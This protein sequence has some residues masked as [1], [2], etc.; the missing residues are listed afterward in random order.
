MNEEIAV[1]LLQPSS[2]VV[3]ATIAVLTLLATSAV[4]RAEDLGHIYVLNARANSVEVFSS[5]RGG[6]ISP[7]RVISGSRTQISD[8][9]ELAVDP[10]GTV[11][12]LTRRPASIVEFSPGAS[13]N[14][15]PQTVLTGPH[16]GLLE[17][18]GLALGYGDA[19]FLAD[20]MS[21]V[22]IFRSGASG[23]AS[24][25]TTYGRQYGIGADISG[26]GV[27]LL[28]Q[29]FYA[30]SESNSV[31]TIQGVA[32]GYGMLSYKLAGPQSHLNGPKS[33]SVDGYGRIYVSNRDN[34]VLFF[35][36]GAR[37]D[38]APTIDIQGKRTLLADPGISGFDAGS[39]IFTPSRSINAVME[40]DPGTTGDARPV[41][42]IRGSRTL[43]DDPISVFYLQ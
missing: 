36:S 22:E 20:K 6:N 35:A 40:F 29:I 26:I 27:D 23:D 5:V 28:G 7:I 13:G 33:L 19:V 38:I 8:P 12:V 14:V 21:G 2:Q 30:S 31:T 3:A 16:T 17:P 1:R 11:F 41:M 24:P 25:T 39:C 15:V 43:L 18:V 9:V 34:S 32:P 37:G 42:V 4:A 10:K